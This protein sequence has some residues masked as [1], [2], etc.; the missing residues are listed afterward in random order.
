MKKIIIAL[1]CLIGLL[2]CEQA[3]DDRHVTI[4]TNHGNIV[5]ELNREK[6]P[7]SVANFLSYIDEGFYTDTIFH[8][9]I[10]NFM[11]QGGGYTTELKKKSGK[12]PIK[13]E[14]ENG[15][16]NLRGTIAMA[17]TSAVNSATNEFFINHADNG[18]LDHNVQGF[19]Y[20]VFG[21]VVAGMDVVDAIAAE[22]TVNKNFVF[23]NYPEK[24]V[25][26]KKIVRG[27]P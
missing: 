13:N 17:R 15:L 14:A 11:I 2:G 10:A 25:I 18:F 27:K 21:K 8:R 3:K 24:Q 12:Q 20:A 1:V 5:V 26:I 7:I 19:G 4:E 6:A 16:K 23:A 9:V 22:K